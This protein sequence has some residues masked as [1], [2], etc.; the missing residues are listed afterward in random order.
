MLLKKLVGNRKKEKEKERAFLENGSKVLEKLVASCN[1]RPIP[2]RTFSY[3][4]LSRATNNFDH[5]LVL[6]KH[7]WYILYKGSFEGRT[8]SVKKYEM[9][10]STEELDFP[11]TDI[12]IS[13]KMSPHKNALKLLGCCL[14]TRF[15][16]LVLESVENGTLK[17]RIC[18]SSD[19]EAQQKLRPMAWQSRLKIAREIAHAIAYLHTAFSRPII[20]RDIQPHNIFFDQHDVPK[21]SDFSISVSIP[22]G[23]T[24]VEDLVHGTYGF[25]CPQHVATGRVTERSDVYGFGMLLL[26][27]ITGQPSKNMCSHPSLANCIR[28]NAINEIVDPAILAGEGGAGVEWQLLAVLELVLICR[29]ED[30]ELRPNMVDVTKELRRIEKSVVV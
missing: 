25:A 27:L 17:D 23:E 21:L 6:D 3:E 11:F 8:I 9:L 28:N 13:A 14:E 10:E 15:P 5:R 16:I 30:S 2:I 12:A 24:H 26:Q 7:L 22:E 4:E 1:G 18:A 19:D 29:N 20:H